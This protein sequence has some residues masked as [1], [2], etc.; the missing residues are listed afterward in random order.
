MI[1]FSILSADGRRPLAACFLPALRRP[2]AALLLS[3]GMRDRKERYLVFA[4]QAAHAGI[5]ILVYDANAHGASICPGEVRGRAPRGVPYEEILLADL[6][7]MAQILAERAPGLPLFACGHS[8]GS[9]AVRHL[10][11]DPLPWRGLLMLSTGQFSPG[12]LSPLFRLAAGEARLQI[13]HPALTLPERLFFALLNAPFRPHQTMADWTSR[14][15]AE[16]LRF[17]LD[18]GWLYDAPALWGMERLIAQAPD[19]KSRALLRPEIA[20]GFFSGEADLL[21]AFGVGPRLLALRAQAAGYPDVTLA[22]Y[23]GARHDLL[24]EKNAAEVRRQL[25]EWILA[26]AD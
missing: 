5:A 3:H 21:G 23:P 24:H 14:D 18:A 1:P 16:A 20:L 22:L 8:L 13:A 7:Q 4:R 19:F 15:G 11:Y 26:R 6:A 12:A 2:R 17:A 9:F 10:L 25:I